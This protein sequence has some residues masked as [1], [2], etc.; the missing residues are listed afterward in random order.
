M[1]DFAG[2]F[3]G[4]GGYDFGSTSSSAEASGGFDRSTTING[5][6]TKTL[7]IMAGVALVGLFMLKG[8]K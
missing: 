3:G 4:G 5:I 2:A 7:A 8:R 6:D 1:W